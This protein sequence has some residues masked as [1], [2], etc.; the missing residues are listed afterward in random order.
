MIFPV[1]KIAISND[2]H[3]GKCIDFGWWKEEYRGQPILA[4]DNGKV[5]SVENQE[6]G[7]NVVYIKHDNGIVSCYAHLDKVYAKKG[8]N[9]ILGEYVG[10]M[11]STGKA[12]TG[13]HLHFGL[14]SK[15]KNMYGY[16]DLNIFDYCYVYPN[17][18]V[19]KS[20]TKYLN[21][22]R[23]YE[24]NPYTT[25]NYKLLKNKYIRTGAYIPLQDKDNCIKVKECG[26]WIKPK[27]VSTKPNDWAIIKAGAIVEITEIVKE[28]NGRIWGKLKNTYIV[29]QNIDGTPQAK[30]V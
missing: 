23:Y 24:E 4:C 29:L 26:S 2:Y 11:G 25:G 3:Y 1:N 21:R 10:T 8:N 27:L 22:F 9:I 20:R 28:N 14:Y 13:M 12:A 19:D 5:I 15:G 16:S 17:Q 30:K 6:N 18:E 7:G